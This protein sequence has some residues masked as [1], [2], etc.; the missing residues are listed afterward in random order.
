MTLLALFSAFLLPLTLITSFYWMNIKL[1][2]QEN[3]LIVYLILFLIFFIMILGYNY[4][5]KKWN[6]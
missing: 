3:A 4:S 5:K 1:P 6:F 2:F